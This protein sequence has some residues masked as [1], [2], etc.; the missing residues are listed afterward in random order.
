M[1]RWPVKTRILWSPGD[2][3]SFYFLLLGACYAYSVDFRP[4]DRFW[5]WEPKRAETLK[6]HKTRLWRQEELRKVSKV[7]DLGKDFHGI[8]FV[9]NQD[10]THCGR[11]YWT[12]AQQVVEQICYQQYLSYKHLFTEVIYPIIWSRIASSY[13]PRMS[14]HVVM[15]SICGYF[16]CFRHAVPFTRCFVALSLKSKGRNSVTTKVLKVTAFIKRV[17]LSVTVWPLIKLNIS[18][19][20]ISLKDYLMKRSLRLC[21]IHIVQRY[22]D[23]ACV[24]A[25]FFSST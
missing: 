12:N 16:I 1:S 13:T 7:G 17:C 6:I 4:R 10:M 3:K 5:V 2:W 11:S 22:A 9:W 19:I 18:S 25:K 24:S 21:T 23:H 8:Q 15:P 20:K 14:W